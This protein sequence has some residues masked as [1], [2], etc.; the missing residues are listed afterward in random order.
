[1]DERERYLNIQQF[2]SLNRLTFCGYIEEETS[3]MPVYQ[4]T[5]ESGIDLDVFT[6]EGVFNDVECEQFTSIIDERAIRREV[7][8]NNN[9]THK[10]IITSSVDAHVH[11]RIISQLQKCQDYFQNTRKFFQE[12]Y[13]FDTIEMRCIDGPT[14]MHADGMVMTGECESFPHVRGLSY[15][16][17]LNNDFEG[18]ELV[19][20]SKHIIHKVTK[21][22]AVIF[23]PMWSHP[24][25]TNPNMDN[26]FR[27]TLTTWSHSNLFKEDSKVDEQHP[28]R[29]IPD[30]ITM[31]R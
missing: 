18:G 29:R 6:V 26:T 10:V 27:Y 1:M 24:H 5:T 28:Q 3:S 11:E 8:C 21:G 31:G 2:P 19:F 12:K 30:F 14:R 4:Y 7:A 23:P 15:V 20:P 17:G 16:V 13:T 22:Q 25:F 9:V